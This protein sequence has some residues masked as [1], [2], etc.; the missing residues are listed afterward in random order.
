MW[1][2]SRWHGAFTQP[3]ALPQSPQGRQAAG[4]GVHPIARRTRDNPPPTHLPSGARQKPDAGSTEGR[5][6]RSLGSADF[7]PSPAWPVRGGGALGR[8]PR[9][10]GARFC[11]RSRWRGHSHPWGGDASRQRTEGDA[12]VLRGTTTSLAP[13]LGP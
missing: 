10:S 5:A 8:S 13:S 7:R 2:R 1:G 3:W 4:S 6:E 9:S 12:S 11:C